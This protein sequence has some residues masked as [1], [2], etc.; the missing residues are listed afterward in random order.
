MSNQNEE[1]NKDNLVNIKKRKRI[2]IDDDIEKNKKVKKIIEEDILITKNNYLLSEIEKLEKKLDSYQEIISNLNSEIDILENK[3]KEKNKKLDKLYHE[4]FERE[5][6]IYEQEAHIEELNEE[7]NELKNKSNPPLIFKF[8]IDLFEPKQ[9]ECKSDKD[10]TD[11]KK[12]SE[13]NEVEEEIIDDSNWEYKVIEKKVCNL[14]DLIELGKLYN[15]DEKI[16]Y[17]INLK[18]LNK[19]IDPLENLKKMIGM[20]KV[21]ETVF[22]QIIYFLQGIDDKNNDMLHCVIEGPPGV[23]KTEVA[24]ILGKIY[25]NM[26]ILTSDKFKSVKRS[27]LIGGYLGQTAIKTQKILDECNGGVLFIDEAYS[28]GNSEGKDS[29]S[30]ECID[31]LTAHLS[32]N[33][34]NFICIIAGYKNS[35]KECFFNYNEGLERRFPYRFQIDKYTPFELSQIFSKIVKENKWC[36]DEN[37]DC[38]FFETNEKYFTFN[39]GDM[40]LLFHKC[41]IAHAKRVFL[42]DKS[43]KK[44]LT[45]EDLD[46]GLKLLLVNEEIANRKE[47]VQHLFNM[48]T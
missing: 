16:K 12:S 4:S 45:N 23:G 43:K 42:L 7:L 48:Y 19:L 3:E 8:P 35:L 21:K 28:L 32:E 14:D 36:I 17:N 46:Q 20:K 22:N 31:T 33:K 6:Y 47:K 30:K 24:K 5:E 2:E 37:M 13:L 1:N 38:S 40:E 26:G 29:Y 41:K 18:I 25:K 34:Q 15:P 10:N 44:I 9:P 39:G 11:K 27:Q